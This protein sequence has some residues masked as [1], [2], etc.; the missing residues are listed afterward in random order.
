MYSKFALLELHGYGAFS[1][2]IVSALTEYLGGL[3]RGS[4]VFVK[5]A[6]K[7]QDCQGFNESLNYKSG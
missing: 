3:M 5:R 1:T 7:Y 6:M 2:E 4:F